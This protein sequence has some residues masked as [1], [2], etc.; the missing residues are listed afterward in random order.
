[1]KQKGETT[2]EFEHDAAEK[3]NTRG[4]IRGRRRHSIQPMVAE[5]AAIGVGLGSPSPLSHPFSANL[6][7]QCTCVIT[8]CFRGLFTGPRFHDESFLHQ[9]EHPHLVHN[10]VRPVAPRIP[11]PTFVMLNTQSHFADS[12]VGITRNH[13]GDI[14]HIS[15]SVRAR[16]SRARCCSGLPNFSGVYPFYPPDRFLHCLSYIP[17]AVVGLLTRRIFHPFLY[18]SQQQIAL[19][20]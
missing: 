11:Q 19:V 8:S 10:I 5:I 17:Y 12:T 15:E 2:A 14:P 4:K 6:L 1:M 16:R 9:L 18:H 3:G 13:I 7:D 20:L